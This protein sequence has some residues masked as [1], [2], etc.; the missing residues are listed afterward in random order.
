MAN[1][2]IKISKDGY[3]VG[4]ASLENL[5]LSSKANQFKI[6]LQGSLTFTSDNQTKTVSHNLSYTPSYIAFIKDS[7]NSYYNFEFGGQSYI[8]DSVLS[9]LAD[10]DDIISYLIFKDIGA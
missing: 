9:F 3:N 10:T 5:V 7:A 8:D 6:H 2:G 4:T 1:Y